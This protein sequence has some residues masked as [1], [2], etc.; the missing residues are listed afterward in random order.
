MIS[1][2]YNLRHEANQGR[3]ATAIEIRKVHY[4]LE[5]RAAILE[6]ELRAPTSWPGALIRKNVYALPDLC[7]PAERVLW[8]HR[9]PASGH[10]DGIGMTCEEISAPE[11]GLACCCGGEPGSLSLEAPLQRSRVDY[12]YCGE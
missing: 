7:Q 2:R 3:I 4:E 5:Y 1:W 6:D 10:Q 11:N 12:E 8:G 9:A